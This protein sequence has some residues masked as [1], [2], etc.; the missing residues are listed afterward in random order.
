M[1]VPLNTGHLTL[2]IICCFFL[3]E[4]YIWP[5]SVTRWLYSQLHTLDTICGRRI[6]LTVNA[7]TLTK[8]TVTSIKSPET[9]KYDFLFSKP[10]LVPY[11]KAWKGVEKR[12]TCLNGPVYPC[13][14]HDYAYVDWVF[15]SFCR[16]R[17][18]E[19]G[20]EWWWAEPTMQRPQTTQTL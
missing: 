20:I 12:S 17:R 16:R 14:V 3:G 18:K 8:V 9:L 5:A 6:T 15:A 19:L 11:L 10:N 4:N 13:D 2:T 1:S 7:N